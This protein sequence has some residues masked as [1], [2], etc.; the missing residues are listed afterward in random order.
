MAIKVTGYKHEKKHWSSLPPQRVSESVKHTD[1]W[2]RSNVDAII[3]MSQSGSE[4]G[5][6]SRYNKQINYDI[7]NSRFKQSDFS[8]VLNPHGISDTRF[9]GS[10][11]KMQNYNII[12]RAFETLKGE[13]MKLGM[14]YRAVAVNG[15]AT[16]EKNAERQKAIIEAMKARIEAV[17]NEDI[18]PE[19]GEP[20]APDP[21]QVANSFRTEY[22]HPTEIATN[23]LLKY[24]VKKDNLQ[25]KFSRGWEHA[26]TSAEEL[27][28][29]GIVNGHPSIRVC[30]PLNVSF[31]KE[32][33]NPFIQ[34]GDWAIEERWMP[35]GAVIDLHGDSLSDEDVRRLDEGELGGTFAGAGN[36]Y[37]GFGYDFNGGTALESGFSNNTSHVYVAHCAWRSWRKLGKLSYVDPRTGQVEST[38]VDDRFK[39]TKE[40]KEIGAVVAWY[41]DTEIW[42][43]V[44]IGADVYV[45]IQPLE[46]QTGNLPYIGYMYNN[47]NSSATSLVDMVKPHQYT[48]IIV[49]YRLEQELAKAKGKKFVM[50]IAQLPKSK[51]WTVDQWMYYFDNQGVAWVNSLE[52]GRKGDPSTIS[53]FNQ[54]Q[55]I[56]MTLS[57]SVQQYM[58][59]LQKLEDMVEAITGVSPQRAGNIGA[60]ETATGAQR[61]IIQST[62]NTKPLFFYHDLTREA[63]LQELVELCKVAYADGVN[64]EHA[65]DEKTVET[66]RVDAGL[67]TGTDMGV[68][69]SNSIED[70]ENI[71]KLER[72][73]DAAIQYDKATLTDVVS[74]LGTKSMSEIKDTIVAGERAKIQRDQET[75]E[76]QSNAVREAA[77]INQETEAQKGEITILSEE[78]R[79]NAQI[80]SALINAE[81]RIK[82]DDS[83]LQAE[84]A[85]RRVS[86]DESKARVDEK[87]KTRDVNIRERAQ[88]ETERSNRAKETI[89]RQSKSSKPTKN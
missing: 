28:Y 3:N 73:L 22:A 86:L 27:Y 26:L 74:I 24:I 46:N 5:R 57:Q 72:Y 76:A 19:T 18:D 69:L 71:E 64:I 31:D 33:D 83:A 39:M 60:S 4:T 17:V 87:L 34:H 48:Y 56:D 1:G 40:L 84:V 42:E 49:W 41:W 30:N 58:V 75:Q 70:A 79:A 7:L 38:T 29:G 51:G 10:A 62:N 63:V 25:M 44:R 43:G 50:D 78:I 67:L 21:E 82:D 52:E 66:I 32:S 88:K 20:N 12:R 54:F 77:Q 13:E 16:L 37:P 55:A 61:A 23:K 89:S 81:S 35:K 53:K 80:E 15:E 8:H 47:V 2:K 85:E 45:D 65:L 14:E 36:T 59:I 68:F 11:T 6:S 9:V